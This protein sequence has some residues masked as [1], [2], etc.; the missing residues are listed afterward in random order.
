MKPRIKEA[1]RR[2]KG[3]LSQ[4]QGGPPEFALADSTKRTPD[5]LLRIPWLLRK[6]LITVARNVV[7]IF[8]REVGRREGGVRFLKLLGAPTSLLLGVSAQ[9][10]KRFIEWLCA[11]AAAA[12]ASHSGALGFGSGAEMR[13][14]LSGRKKKRTAFPGIARKASLLFFSCCLVIKYQRNHN[15]WDSALSGVNVNR[16]EHIYGFISQRGAQAEGH[17][18]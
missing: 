1:Q 7:D 12:A 3:T 17:V 8:H 18:G 2:S 5:K 15:T 4:G 9:G 6:Y 14:S 13:S 16:T 11:A 10:S